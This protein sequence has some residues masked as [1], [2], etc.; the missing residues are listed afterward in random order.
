MVL[1]PQPEASAEQ[2][3]FPEP[4][5]FEEEAGG[6]PFLTPDDETTQYEMELRHT[7][8]IEE[9]EPF[10]TDL[11]TNPLG[12]QVIVTQD[13]GLDQQKEY[14]VN[15]GKGVIARR[16]IRQHA[17]IYCKAEV[18]SREEYISRTKEGLGGYILNQLTVFQD[19]RS[20]RLE[21]DIASAINSAT[22]VWCFATGKPATAICTL[23][24]SP[25][26]GMFYYKLTRDVLPGT[27]IYASYGA[28]YRM[29]FHV[30]RMIINAA[31]STMIPYGKPVFDKLRQVLRNISF[32]TAK[33]SFEVQ[34]LPEHQASLLIALHRRNYEKVTNL[35]LN[36]ASF[37]TIIREQK[38][39]TW[40]QGKGLCWIDTLLYIRVTAQGIAWPKWEHRKGPALALVHDIQEEIEEGKDMYLPEFLEDLTQT[41]KMTH[42]ALQNDTGVEKRYWC[43][44]WM[45][46]SLDKKIPKCLFEKVDNAL[47]LTR[48]TDSLDMLHQF[49]Y[50]DIVDIATGKVACIQLDAEHYMPIRAPFS[51]TDLQG[52]TDS[53]LTQL[54]NVFN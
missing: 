52:M 12:L 18:I 54:K 10:I 21:G 23:H 38:G 24:Y 5:A 11:T 9:D 4:I 49:S 50:Q 45:I 19:A 3:P 42:Q 16:F 37:R 51:L 47:T 25:K 26:K 27:P 40:I 13:K 46:R 8:Q 2:N 32:Q 53:L 28:S 43:Q 36:T 34:F 33:A 20:A 35:L 6:I 22:N 15:L 17:K 14:T 1:D 41:L 31:E 30:G 7:N 44:S 39:I 48:L 29:S